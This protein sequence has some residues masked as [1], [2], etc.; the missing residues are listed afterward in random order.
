[1]PHTGRTLALPHQE[2]PA[3]RTGSCICPLATWDA[4]KCSSQVPSLTPS[5][6]GRPDW[7]ARECC[8]LVVTHEYLP[9]YYAQSLV[10]GFMVGHET[11]TNWFPPSRS[12]ASV[13]GNQN[14][15]TDSELEKK[16]IVE[17]SMCRNSL[18]RLWEV[19]GI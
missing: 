4:E 5:Y 1:M 11:T 3:A 7:P 12:S 10:P 13:K 6:S 16:Q 15:S 14:N 2:N 9:P 18:D 8:C 17:A 19:V